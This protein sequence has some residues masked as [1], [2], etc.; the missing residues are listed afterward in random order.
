MMGVMAP[1]DLQC[2]DGTMTALLGCSGAL[3]PPSFERVADL[4]FER[5]DRW[6]DEETRRR[7][8]ARHA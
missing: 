6:G 4:G 5:G 8:R 1:R 3:L 7:E 2:K